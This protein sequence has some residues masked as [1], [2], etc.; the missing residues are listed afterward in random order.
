MAGTSASAAVRK[1][2]DISEI[3]IAES[4]LNL[5]LQ[6]LFSYRMILRRLLLSDWDFHCHAAREKVA[7][8][9]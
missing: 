2:V 4:F 8:P 1:S 6:L 3:F 9:R 5:H 7:I